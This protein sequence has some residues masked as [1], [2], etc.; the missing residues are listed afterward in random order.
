MEF[1]F[2]QS[3]STTRISLRGNLSETSDFGPV[4]EKLSGDVVLDLSELARV[5]SSGVR[6]WVRFV[7]AIP[8]S[9]RLVLE[10]CPV[11]FVAQI[12][13]IKNFL[14]RAGIRSMFLPYYCSSCD[15][16]HQVLANVGD[17]AEKGLPGSPACPTCGSSMEFDALEDEYLGFLKS[18]RT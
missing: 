14:G 17:L 5:N 16:S 10:R 13:M 1:A 8:A 11:Q 7:Q 3:G 9:A 6:E 15:G 2:E 12:N 4:L 18:A